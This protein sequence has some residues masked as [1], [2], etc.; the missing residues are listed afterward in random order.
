MSQFKEYLSTL[1]ISGDQFPV[2]VALTVEKMAE[3]FL[4]KSYLGV[5]ETMAIKDFVQFVKEEMARV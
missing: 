4:K 3:I 5:E 2:V 1:I